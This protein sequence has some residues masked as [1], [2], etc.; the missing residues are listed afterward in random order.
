MFKLRTTNP[1]H[2][3]DMWQEY[4]SITRE[5]LC[6]ILGS[7]IS[8]YQWQQATL[9]V[10]AGGL[11]LRLAEDHCSAAHLL[12]VGI[13]ISQIR[14]IEKEFRRMSPSSHKRD[15]AEAAS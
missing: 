14:N 2:H 13:Q 3:L 4:D 12:F 15:V 5:S 9:P 7:S 6:R 1:A 8:N 11:G 10:S